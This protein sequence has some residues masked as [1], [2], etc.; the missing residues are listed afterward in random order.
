MGTLMCLSLHEREC[1]HIYISR[2]IMTI[3]GEDWI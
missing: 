2:I 3:P 1:I